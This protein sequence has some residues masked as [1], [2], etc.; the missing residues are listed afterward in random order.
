M[1][2]SGQTPPRLKCTLWSEGR[3]VRTFAERSNFGDIANLL[4]TFASSAFARIA[5]I[6][7][8]GGVSGEFECR[9]DVGLGRSPPVGDTIHCEIVPPRCISSA[10]PICASG[11][12][13]ANDRQIGAFRNRKPRRSVTGGVHLRYG[14]RPSLI[15]YDELFLKL[16]HRALRH[17]KLE[18]FVGFCGCGSDSRCRDIF[19]S[20]PEPRHLENGMPLKPFGR[21]HGSPP[22]CFTLA[23]V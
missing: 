6:Q 14:S 9:V 4:L 5:D 15:M 19:G 17:L 22:S 10:C 11:S 16:S 21:C 1:F 12:N 23:T 3:L 20:L 7:A 8:T 2:T 18:Q 13:S